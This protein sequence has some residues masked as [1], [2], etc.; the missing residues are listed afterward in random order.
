MEE[1]IE[2]RNVVIIDSTIVDGH[3]LVS[4]LPERPARTI[5]IRKALT[6]KFGKT[7][8][9]RKIDWS[10]PPYITYDEFL[11]LAKC[12]HKEDYLVELTAA[13]NR[14]ESTHTLITANS[15]TDCYIDE[16]TRAAMCASL[17]SV[18][19]ALYYIRN[20][21]YKRAFCNIRPPGHH[22]C[23]HKAMGFCMVN[24]IAI[25]V[26]LSGMRVAIIDWDNHHG[27]GTQDIFFDDQ[28]VLYISLHGDYR[29]NY[30]GTGHPDITGMYD[31]IMNINLEV[32]SGHD[33][34]V[35][36]FQQKLIPKLHA[37][38]P[39]IIFISC[40]F[41]S[42]ELD[43]I[44]CLKFESH[45]YGYMTRELVKIADQYCDGRII[46]M[47]EGGYNIQ[48]LQESSVEHIQAML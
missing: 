43:P 8:S 29:Y 2:S 41:D 22:A 19:L 36:V 33:V 27:N 16:R 5:A 9:D 46:S 4:P 34:V 11:D 40:G 24:N 30:P 15:D 37:F 10:E 23:A 13:L 17:S 21:F 31:N 20:G 45:T 35:D 25:G 47:L 18:N 14:A 26:R 12:I 44:G 42:H 6:D 3:I 28:N 1:I 32:H 39:E 7:E 48:A 38:K